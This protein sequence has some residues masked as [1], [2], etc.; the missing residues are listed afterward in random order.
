MGFF[1]DGE[2]AVV[3]C[4]EI[5]VV[6]DAGYVVFFGDCFSRWDVRGWGKVFLVLR[7]EM[8][9]RG[10]GRGLEKACLFRETVSEEGESIGFLAV[11]LVLLSFALIFL[12][13]MLAICE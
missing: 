6:E 1:G 9:V 7:V 4:G 10:P 13:V 3:D 8:L 11:F 5:E 12:V 2:G